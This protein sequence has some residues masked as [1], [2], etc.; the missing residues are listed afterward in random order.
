MKTGFRS[1]SPAVGIVVSL[2]SLAGLAA[3]GQT[4]YTV[5]WFSI[6]AGGGTSTS[7]VYS[8]TGTIGQ[9]DAGAMSCGNYTL[10]GGFWSIVAAVQTP[11]AARL[12]V[13]R[14]NAVVIV[15]WPNSA[16]VWNLEYA[17]MLTGATNAWTQFPLPYQT[18]AMDCYIT[19]PSPSGNRFYRLKK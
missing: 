17:T 10:V 15:S 2:L 11:C 9:P 8:V 5:D 1:R 14:S 19:E 4:N 3:R 16:E 18:N 12:S 6:D 13:T 7:A